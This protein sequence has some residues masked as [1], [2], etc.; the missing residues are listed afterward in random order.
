[1]C[2]SVHVSLLAHHLHGAYLQLALLLSR[3]EQ[4][5]TRTDAAGCPV[6]EVCCMAR[7][8]TFPPAC[9]ASTPL[10][11]VA[12]PLER[13][14]VK[15]GSH[16]G[17]P[18]LPAPSSPAA[19]G[20]ALG[21]LLHC[22]PSCPVAPRAI[23]PIYFAHME[24]IKMSMYVVTTCYGWGTRVQGVRWLHWPAR[25]SARA[26][27]RGRHATSPSFYFGGCE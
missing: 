27:A 2:V 18:P 24:I 13:P 12:R 26:S 8:G 14:H 10:A 3:P 25:A 20:G 1:M 9:G 16:P 15:L 21:Y 17:V 22:S 7:S 11:A 5:R 19:P 23:R 6:A 4:T